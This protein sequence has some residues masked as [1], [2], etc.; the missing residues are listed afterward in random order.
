MKIVFY[1]PNAGYKD[2]DCSRLEEGNPGLGGT[3][4]VIMVTAILLVRK[5]KEKNS[6]IDLIVAAQDLSISVPNLHLVKVEGIKD[7]AAMHCDFIFFKYEKEKYK[8]LTSE[9]NKRY[10]SNDEYIPKIVIWAHNMIDR[11]ERN[12]IDKDCNVHTVLCVSR[13]QM[14]LYR[15]HHLFKKST[16][17]NNG[18]PIEYL[19]SQRQTIPSFSSRPH[20]VTSIGSIDYYKGFHLI[21][22]VW[23]DVLAAVPDAKLNVIGSGALY[24][25][26]SKMGKYGLAEES[27]EN[28]FIPYITDDDGK[29][30]PSVKFF[31]VM[32][33]EK[34]EVLKRTR[35]GVPNPMGKETF[36]IVALEMQAMGALVTTMNYGG[37]RNTVFK[38]GLLYED[39]KDLTQNIITLLKANENNLDD[40]YKWMEDNFSYEKIAQEWYEFIF[41]L[42]EDRVKKG[43]KRVP[44]DSNSNGSL[45]TFREVNRKLKNIFG[46]WLPTIE[47]Y[48]SILRRIG[49]VKGY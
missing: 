37:F 39:A 27:Y 41:A 48:R 31:G 20:E 11:K 13:E 45:E 38:T 23:K 36:C 33:I 30:L 49:F 18:M 8:V 5:L 6:D 42:F 17:I 26:D 29:I 4:Y 16:Y 14:N 2:I 3:E 7:V 28:M 10:A 40:C 32:G 35:V 25:R 12:V 34:N 19:R 9:I 22:K 15:D 44:Y 21:A 1:L 24:N 43:E 47:F 46:Y